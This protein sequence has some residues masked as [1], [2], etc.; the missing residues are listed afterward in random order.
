VAR[1]AHGFTVTRQGL[2]DT[3]TKLMLK[4]QGA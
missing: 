1:E 3:L 4:E 2:V